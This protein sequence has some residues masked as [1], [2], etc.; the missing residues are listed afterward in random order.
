MKILKCDNAFAS[1][2]ETLETT[3]G[4]GTFLKEIEAAKAREI[5]LVL[6][7][8]ATGKNMKL[9]EKVFEEIETE[10]KNEIKI[11]NE[12]EPK[13]LKE[14]LGIMSGFV[15]NVLGCATT[16]LPEIVLDRELDEAAMYSHYERKIMIASAEGYGLPNLVAHE[17]VH[18]L[19]LSTENP[20]VWYLNP[21][22][23]EGL[24]ECSA[25][26]A[27]R[28]YGLKSRDYAAVNYVPAKLAVDVATCLGQLGNGLHGSIR[29]MLIDKEQELGTTALL[30]AEKRHGTGIYRDMI[31]A[32]KP[33]EMLVEMLGGRK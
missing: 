18:H 20:G 5:Y 21:V 4:I 30:I 23:R 8:L 16:K 7:V 22:S 17:Y 10:M 2:Q 3:K 19:Q 32:E 26:I 1:W 11:F 27:T 14:W 15:N 13:E 24:A 9:A 6:S 28:R 33:G 29:R 31:R 12:P 25:A